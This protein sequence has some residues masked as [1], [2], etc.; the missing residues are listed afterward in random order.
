MLFYS[1]MNTALLLPLI[2]FAFVSSITPGPN[3]LMILASGLNYG[4]RRSLPHMLGIGIGFMFMLFLVG[5]GLAE[6]FERF[7]VLDIILKV[8]ATLYMI[9]LAWRIANAGSPKAAAAGARPM[10]FLEACAFQWVNPKAWAMALTAMTVY[11][12]EKTL[13][14]IGIVTLVFGI[15]NIPCVGCWAILGQ[16]MRRFLQSPRA[17]RLFNWSM[18]ILL[19][20]SLYPILA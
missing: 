11:A 6:L 20:A 1:A 14:E 18:A 5:Y 15:V 2:G 7:P 16:E 17:L 10:S 13:L 12:P 19:I 4:L 8:S 9:W 3:N